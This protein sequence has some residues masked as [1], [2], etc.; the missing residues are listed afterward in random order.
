MTPIKVP[1]DLKLRLLS[2]ADE[3]GAP[4]LGFARP[5]GRAVDVAK[6]AEQAKIELGFDGTSMLALIEAGPQAL[7]KVRG[8][9]FG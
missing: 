6:A 2:Y 4:R 9:G 1:N 7:A 8:A 5:D 3:S